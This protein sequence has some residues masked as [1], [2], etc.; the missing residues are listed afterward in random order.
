MYSIVRVAAAS[1]AFVLTLPVCAAEP[2]AGAPDL[3]KAQ[4]TVNQV[5]VACHGADGNSAAPI[6]PNL[7][8]QPARYITTQLDH[9][10]AGV[11][12]NPMMAPMSTNLSDEDMKSLGAFFAKQQ[13]K[14]SAA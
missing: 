3:A 14:G 4:Q 1:A 13:P 12:A 2:Q 7:A 11:R 9:Y 5:C 8:G 10:K 6:Y